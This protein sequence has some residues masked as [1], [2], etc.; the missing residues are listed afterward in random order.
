MFAPVTATCLVA[1]FDIASL[2]AYHQSLCCSLCFSGLCL[3]HVCM[4]MRMCVCCQVPTRLAVLQRLWPMIAL[5]Q[6]P[7]DRLTA[8][9]HSW[10]AALDLSMTSSTAAAQGGG[11]SK[12]WLCP[13]AAGAGPAIA[14]RCLC[15]VTALHTAKTQGRGLSTN[16]SVSYIPG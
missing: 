4:H 13:Y 7:T 8:F 5:L 10:R 12:Q 3:M 16:M 11:P 6:S 9:A 2:G 15:D 1:S 14:L